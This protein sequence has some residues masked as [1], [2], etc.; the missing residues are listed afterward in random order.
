MSFLCHSLQ[1]PS[2]S[3]F[4]TPIPAADSGL[5]PDVSLVVSAYEA[6]QTGNECLG[7]ELTVYA[8]RSR[9]LCNLLAG[10]DQ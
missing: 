10:N 2:L 4:T 6:E 7:R 1:Q 9:Q 3:V 5:T 8:L